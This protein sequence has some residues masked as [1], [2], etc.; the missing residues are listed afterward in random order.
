MAAATSRPLACFLPLS[1]A[2]RHTTAIR[3]WSLAIA[4]VCATRIV[5]EA[6]DVKVEYDKAYDFKNVRTWGWN[7]EGPGQVKMARTK[8]DDPEAMRKFTEPIIVETVS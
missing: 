7:P 8:D 6:V 2:M 5:I 3:P 1:S 4:L